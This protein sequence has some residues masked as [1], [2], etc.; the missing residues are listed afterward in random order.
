MLETD[1]GLSA[2]LRRLVAIVR[3]LRDPQTGCEWDLVQTHA[4]LA[5]FAIEEAYELADAIRAGSDGDVRDECGDVVFQVVLHAQLASERNAFDL[6]DVLQGISD[7]MERRHPH[8]FGDAARADWEAIKASERQDSS[9]RSA[10]AGVAG[11]LPALS[12]AAKLGARAARVGFDWTG[13]TGV[14]DKVVEE[15][16]EIDSA[17]D[18]IERQ[19]EFG[20]LLFTLVSWARHAGID[21]E[22]AL[23]DANTKFEARFRLMEAAESP[24][25][26]VDAIGMES[27]WA[28]AKTRQRA[29]KRDQSASDNRTDSDNDPSSATDRSSTSPRS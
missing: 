29:E 7:K 12:R 20:D 8:I 9:D 16:N 18:E 13:V 28:R 26:D 19:E 15:L 5:P 25:D 6:T 14:L 22:T 24:L 3:R 17:A 11:T 2:A 4:S 27:A 23:R 10:L 21:A 1:E